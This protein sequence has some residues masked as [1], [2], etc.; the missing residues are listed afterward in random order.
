LAESGAFVVT[1]GGI[2][3]KPMDGVP[4]FVREWVGKN[5]LDA[6]QRATIIKKNA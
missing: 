3:L 6:E 4:P 5:L 2:A 1:T